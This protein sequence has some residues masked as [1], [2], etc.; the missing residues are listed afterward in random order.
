MINIENLH[1]A[2]RKKQPLFSDLRL[3][4]EE[5]KIYGLLGKNGTGKSTLLKLM[6]GGLAPNQGKVILNKLS[7]ADRKP[8]LLQD[9]YY[10]PEEL[11]LPSLKIDTYLQAYAPFYPKFDYNKFDDLLTVF[12]VDRHSNMSKLSFGQKKKVSIAFGMASQVKYLLMDEPTNGLDIPSKSQFRKALLKGFKEDQVIIISTHQIRDLNQL[13]ESVI[14]L[15]EGKIIFHKDTIEIENKLYFSKHL[16]QEAL[17]DLIYS[18]NG[19][20]GYVHIQPNNEG[21]SSEV[22]L[23]ILFNAVITQKDLVN[24]HLN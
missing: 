4:L 2:Y 7:A 18:E 21:R 5:G 22:E 3:K 12:E 10:L 1:F 14:I 6:I 13:I 15:D 11:D 9:I 20:G 19:T 8:A 23:E 24:Q 16:T 17:P